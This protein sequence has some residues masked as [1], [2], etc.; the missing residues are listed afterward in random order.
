MTQHSP[1]CAGV[2]K[3]TFTVACMEKDTQVMIITIAVLTQKNYNAAVNLLLPSPVFYNVNHVQIIIKEEFRHFSRSCCLCFS[4]LALQF[5]GDLFTFTIS[6]LTWMTLTLRIP[7]SSP[8]HR[9]AVQLAVCKCS[10]SPL[11]HAACTLGK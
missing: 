4:L 10:A 9:S 5:P 6:P 7:I 11:S 2:G 1:D 8:I 3:S